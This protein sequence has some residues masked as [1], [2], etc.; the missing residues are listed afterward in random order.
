MTIS[1]VGTLAP[2]LTAQL[3]T[4]VL[5]TH[6]GLR[7]GRVRVGLGA[8]GQDCMVQGAW[9]EDLACFAGGKQYWDF[10]LDDL[11]PSILGV[12]RTVWSLPGCPPAGWHS[13]NCSAS[14]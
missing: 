6:S 13:G 10:L 5:G 14:V 1:C 7:Q 9:S 8:V 11:S 2:G 12:V 4:A 3:G